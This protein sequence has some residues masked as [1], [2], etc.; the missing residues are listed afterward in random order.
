MSRKQSKRQVKQDGLSIRSG[1]AYGLVWATKKLSKGLGIK[2]SDVCAQN[3]KL[4]GGK[5][6]GWSDLIHSF[7]SLNR[8]SGVFK[9]LVNWLKA[10]GTNRL[11]NTEYRA[12]KKYLLE[13]I[14]IGLINRCMVNESVLYPHIMNC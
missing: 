8:Y 10:R 2:K 7:S 14:I 6:R 9:D 11:D 12:V 1:L 3:R 13:K 4:N 5:G